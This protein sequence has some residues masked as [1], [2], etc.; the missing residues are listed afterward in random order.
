MENFHPFPS[1]QIEEPQEIRKLKFVVYFFIAYPLFEESRRNA[2]LSKL[3]FIQ[4]KSTW[5]TRGTPSLRI[6][7]YINQ[8]GSI[9]TIRL[10]KSIVTN[11][12]SEKL[13]R[14]YPH[15]FP[16]IFFISFNRREPGFPVTGMIDRRSENN[17]R[18][19][20]RKKT[21]GKRNADPVREQNDIASDEEKGREKK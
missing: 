13:L 15:P 7:D 3:S 12:S 8:K 10:T 5:D 19:S 11:V 21:E 14:K 16:E 20:R 2:F 9:W 4:K 1:P 6:I 17:L 18:E